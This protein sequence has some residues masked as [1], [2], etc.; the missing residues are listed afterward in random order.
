SPILVVGRSIMVLEATVVR[1]LTSLGFGR[2]TCLTQPTMEE[3]SQTAAE[4]ALRESEERFRVMAE[5]VPDILFTCRSDGECD[6]IT[7]NFYALTG[8]TPEEALGRG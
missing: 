1:A 7:S 6:F 4:R 3:Q 2:E 5:T 8:M